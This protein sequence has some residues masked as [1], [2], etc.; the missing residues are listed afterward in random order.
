MLAPAAH[1]LRRSDITRRPQVGGSAGQPWA[2]AGQSDLEMTR[3]YTFV[4]IR[5]QDDLTRAIREELAHAAKKTKGML[6]APAPRARPAPGLPSLVDHRVS[7][8]LEARNCLRRQS[9]S[10]SSPP[11]LSRYF[12]NVHPLVWG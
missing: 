4:A 9:I 12:Q 10:R 5:G 7:Y 2:I 6:A 8:C 1:S 11:S 3:A